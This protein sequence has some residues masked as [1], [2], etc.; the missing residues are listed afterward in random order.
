MRLGEVQMVGVVAWLLN[1]GGSFAAEAV[2]RLF[3]Y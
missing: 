2:D 3:D 1:A